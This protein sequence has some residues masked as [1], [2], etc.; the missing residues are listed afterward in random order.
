MAL[1]RRFPHIVIDEAQDIG[2][3]HQAI[4]ELLIGAGSCVTLIGDPNQGIYDFAGADG[5][6]LTEYHQRPE[7][8]Q[9]SL[10]KNF[11]SAPNIVN[12]ANSLCDRSDVA[13]RSAPD[14]PHGAFFTGYK[15]NQYSQLIVA[16]QGAMSAAGAATTRPR[17]CAVRRSWPKRYVVTTHQLAKVS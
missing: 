2:S 13:A 7:V 16:F 15:H 12:L 14:A 10:K 4:L 9:H 3:V 8:Q 17:S 6:F 1:A 5:K 11:R